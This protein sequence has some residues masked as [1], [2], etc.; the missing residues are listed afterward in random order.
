M[1]W[2]ALREAQYSASAYR[3]N[4]LDP[5]RLFDFFPFDNTIIFLIAY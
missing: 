4:T 5:Y 2:I 1:G 3:S